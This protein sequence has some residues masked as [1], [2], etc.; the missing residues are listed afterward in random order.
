M[1]LPT[2]EILA[3]A[4]GGGG[5]FHPLLAKVELTFDP[6]P[7]G[8]TLEVFTGIILVPPPGQFVFVPMRIEYVSKTLGGDKAVA[9]S[10]GFAHFANNVGT[11][12]NRVNAAGWQDLGVQPVVHAN[13]MNI[14]PS[15]ELSIVFSNISGSN[16]GWAKAS[17]IVGTPIVT[18]SGG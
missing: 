14:A 9:M 1:G 16:D 12:V 15:G 5:G 13:G 6:V 18:I 7:F 2:S 11:P 3:L 17:L 8:N 10:L 4:G